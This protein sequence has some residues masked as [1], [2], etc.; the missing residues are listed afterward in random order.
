ME[1]A[2]VPVLGT[3]RS[4]PKQNLEASWGSC[5]HKSNV[6]VIIPFFMTDKNLNLISFEIITI[7]GKISYIACAINRAGKLICLR[8]CLHGRDRK[9]LIDKLYVRFSVKKLQS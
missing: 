5:F 9:G 6:L 1:S 7:S 3:K 8:A 2:G 4:H